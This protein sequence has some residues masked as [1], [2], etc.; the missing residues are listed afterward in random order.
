M[1]G[2][3]GDPL[4]QLSGQFRADQ[5]L[6]HVIKGIVH[7]L[8]AFEVFHQYCSTLLNCFSEALPVDTVPS[9]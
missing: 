3:Y 6:K 1:E 2:T 9:A 5:I 7:R 8:E 4:V